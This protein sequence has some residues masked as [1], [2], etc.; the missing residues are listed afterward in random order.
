MATVR[1]YG[2]LQRYGHKF[3]LDVLTASEALHALFLQIPGLRKHIENDFYRVRIA[4]NDISEDEVKIGFTAILQADAVI[5]IIPKA[6]GAGGAFQA[7]VGGVM[8]V[9]GAIMVGVLGWTGVGGAVGISLMGAGL[10]LMMG[11]IAMM[12]TKTPK[13]NKDDGS[14]NNNTSF[15]NLDNTIAQ[16]QPL[17]LCYGSMMIGSKVLSQGLSTQ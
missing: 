17:P 14:S 10:G 3:K 4:G 5:H 11:G 13:T 6:V 9:A 16:G 1:F 8:F 2:D 12:L 7:I 15:S